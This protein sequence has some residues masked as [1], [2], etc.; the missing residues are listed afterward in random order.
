MPVGGSRGPADYELADV[1]QLVR[2]LAVELGC[3][4]DD[5]LAPTC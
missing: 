4:L 3:E 5:L 2:A 1:E